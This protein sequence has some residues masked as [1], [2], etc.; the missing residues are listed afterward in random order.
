MATAG[1]GGPLTGRGANLL[2]VD[3]PVKNAEEALSPTVRQKH[4]DWWQSTASTRLEPDGVAIVMATRWHKEDLSGRLLTAADAG[5]GEPVLRLHLPAIAEAGDWLGRRE[6]EALWPQ[7]WSLERLLEIKSGRTPYWWQALYQQRPTQA[8]QAEFPDDYF[9][10]WIWCP[11]DDWPERFEHLVVAV[12]PSKGKDTGDYCALVALG[13]TRGRYFAD[14]IVRR[15]PVH[16][17]C[18]A[19]VNLYRQYRPVRIGLE[20]NAWQDLLEPEMQR[21]S[22]DAGL[23][24]LPI[25]L[26]TNKVNKQVRIGRIGPYLARKRIQFRRTSDA[27]RLVDQ[28]REF[29]LGDH[30][31]GPDGLEMAIRLLNHIATARPRES[32]RIDI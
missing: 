18:Q 27:I 12:D 19:V 23:P 14:A 17:I 22:Q 9:G 1:V 20:A 21:A 28:L 24:P 32:I 10:E 8:T 2:V 25:S 31:D 7:R 11:E 30:D 5:E 16:Q 6:G 15:L 29:P 26:I 13:Y 4:W 3:D